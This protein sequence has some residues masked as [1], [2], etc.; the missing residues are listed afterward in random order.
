MKKQK[1]KQEFE[2]S[3]IIDRVKGFRRAGLFVLAAMCFMVNFILN[4]ESAAAKMETVC[5]LWRPDAIEYAGTVSIYLHNKTDK[6]QQIKSM[7]V[8][9]RDVGPL[10]TKEIIEKPLEFRK[11]YL[12]VKNTDVLWYRIWPNPV[13][14][15]GIAEVIVRLAQKPSG[16]SVKVTLTKENKERFNIVVPI[17]KPMFRINY[18][19]FS[20]DLKTINLYLGKETEKNVNISSVIL[21]GKKVKASIFSPEFFHKVCY[22]K[23]SL[24]KPLKDM[25]LHF[26]RVLSESGESDA[27]MVR[28]A[29]A[30]FVLGALTNSKAA[31]I[32]SMKNQFF[33][34][35]GSC[36]ATS[37]AYIQDPDTG[38]YER[39]A[40]FL[41]PEAFKNGHVHW[42]N[43]WKKGYLKYMHYK[44][45]YF[46]GDEPDG[47]GN[48]P[49][50]CR[51][52]VRKTA[53]C[54]MLDPTALVCVAIDHMAWPKNC[55]AFGGICDCFMVHNYSHGKTSMKKETMDHV[56]HAGLSARPLPH[57]YLSG[58]GKHYM[59]KLG[60]EAVA[61]QVWYALSGGAKGI[62]YYPLYRGMYQKEYRMRWFELAKTNVVLH[63]AGPLF[64]KGDVWPLARAEMDDMDVYTLAVGNEAIV[65]LAINKDY[66]SDRKEGFSFE[67]M[68]EVP[69]DIELPKWFKVKDAFSI[70]DKG[71]TNVDYKVSDG[72]VSLTFPLDLLK[73]VV[74]AGN[75]K[76]RKQ[77]QARYEKEIKPHLKLIEEEK[78][79]FAESLIKK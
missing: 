61:L 22:V 18:V 8:N 55:Y 5:A 3:P 78:R 13:P 20:E 2:S 24:R 45:R 70:T 60:A 50:T 73:L 28:A 17:K 16:D 68:G 41:N 19:S 65:L 59:G 23:I 12:D 29:P 63:L 52:E 77:M 32:K 7:S 11:K 47:H 38:K 10:V 51:K 15:K 39:G 14:A 43:E 58:V 53:F 27:C 31:I 56:Y 72:N 54:R 30:K 69:V 66:I 6:P 21:D 40:G 25:S 4:A 48:W 9:E 57:W 46:L 49:R 44:W 36:N 74:I 79:Q 42:M 1:K 75:T 67:P 62:L 35:V 33:N 34:Y 26:I 37:R 71:L 76:L 64:A